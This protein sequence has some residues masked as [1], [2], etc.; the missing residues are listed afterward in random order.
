MELEMI[1]MVL[2]QETIS[3]FV[4]LAVYMPVIAGMGGNT[5]TQ[6]LAV[7]VRG[8]ALKEIELKTGTK[9]ILK[10]AGTGLVNG[11]IN[12]I[13]VS[14][15]AIIFNQNYLLGLVAGVAMIINMMI[16]GFFG[17]TIP[18]IMKRLG[19]DP[20][21]SAAIFITTATDL[22]GFFV[23]LGLATQVF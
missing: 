8:I 7:M 4:L 3:A 17:S 22:F 1:P 10:E 11:V 14:I 6:T 12:G 21:T 23:F 19:K 13:I 20:A 18:L 2:F 5:G 15:I 9:V 16:A